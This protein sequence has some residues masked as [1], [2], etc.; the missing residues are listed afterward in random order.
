MCCGSNIL[1]CGK[2]GFG[3]WIGCIAT[4]NDCFD[5]CLVEPIVQLTVPPLQIPGLQNLR[6]NVAAFFF[7]WT[8]WPIYKI[9][10]LVRTT[11]VNV[12]GSERT[13]TS[14]EIIT[15][16]AHTTISFPNLSSGFDNDIMMSDTNLRDCEGL[17]QR[18]NDTWSPCL[19]CNKASPVT[20][21]G[22]FSHTSLLVL[23]DNQCWAATANKRPMI[24]KTIDHLPDR[25]KVG[26]D[27]ILLS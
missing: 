3:E 4:I 20:S 19:C 11:M 12:W 16:Q 13:F 2:A 7:N 24:N 27:F 8:T 14:H 26:T 9:I 23:I 18:L 22:D 10:S 21:A 5:Y 25:P 1:N 17:T 6:R 15:N